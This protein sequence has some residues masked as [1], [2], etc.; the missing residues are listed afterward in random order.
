MSFNLLVQSA[1]ILDF[2]NF[3]PRYLQQLL[4]ILEFLI[5]N[6][7]DHWCFQ[8]LMKIILTKRRQFFLFLSPL[9]FGK[10]F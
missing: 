10:D 7:I 8:F 9:D 4:A 3:P 5:P 6:D 2:L 1:A